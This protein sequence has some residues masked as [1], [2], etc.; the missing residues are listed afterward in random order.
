MYRI[1]SHINFGR[2]LARS[3]TAGAVIVRGRGLGVLGS[4]VLG[5]LEPISSVCVCVLKP[6]GPIPRSSV[7]C[8]KGRW[9]SP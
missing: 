6:L 4:P 1:F 7:R 5:A 8:G 2:T 3:P 9:T